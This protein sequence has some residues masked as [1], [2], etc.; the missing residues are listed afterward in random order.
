VE[1]RTPKPYH[2]TSL[3]HT[4]LPFIYLPNITSRIRF[5]PHHHISRFR[6]VIRTFRSRLFLNRGEFCYGIRLNKGEFE[7]ISGRVSFMI[8]FERKNVTRDKIN[9]VFKPLDDAYLYFPYLRVCSF[10]CFTYP[11]QLIEQHDFSFRFDPK[12]SF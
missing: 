3:H 12:Y 8:N 1:V 9:N 4:N 11:S 7:I 6:K 10:R 2:F 5:Y